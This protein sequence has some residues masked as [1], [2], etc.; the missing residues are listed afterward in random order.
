MAGSNLLSDKLWTSCRAAK[1]VALLSG[2]SY[3]DS[4]AKTESITL[5]THTQVLIDD[6]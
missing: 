1:E 3:L 2:L 6:S 4:H 5:D